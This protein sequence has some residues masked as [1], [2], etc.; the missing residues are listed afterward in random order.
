MQRRE[1]GLIAKAKNLMKN[2]KGVL[3][4]FNGIAL[5]LGTLAIVVVI[6]FLILAEIGNNATVAADGNA[7]LAVNQTKSA[8]QNIPTFLPIVVITAI[9]GALLLL[10]RVFRSNK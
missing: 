1:M 7:T 10:V 8:M 3:D 6:I 4:Q 2:K 5:G 9:G